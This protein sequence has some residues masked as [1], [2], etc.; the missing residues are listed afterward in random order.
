M[1]DRTT[2]PIPESLAK[3]LWR[4]FPLLTDATVK[5]SDVGKVTNDNSNPMNAILFFFV[6]TN[7]RNIF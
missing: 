1:I 4:T 3:N 6:N 2:P 5:K 7:I